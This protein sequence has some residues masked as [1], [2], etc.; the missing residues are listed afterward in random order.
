M[1]S[2]HCED[3]IQVN[4]LVVEDNIRVRR[5]IVSLVASQN[6]TCVEC[7]NGDDAIALYRQFHPAWVLMDIKLPGLNGILATRRILAED[8][9]AKIAIVTDYN[10][11]EF[12]RAAERAGAKKYFLKEEMAQLKNFIYSL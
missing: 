1:L 8:P 10:D 12:R 9:Q 3:T 2:S 11:E 4:I 5:E 7:D 6:V